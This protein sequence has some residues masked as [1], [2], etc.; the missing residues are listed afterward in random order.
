[1]KILVAPQFGIGDALMTTPALEI[2]KRYRPSWKIDVFTMKKPINDV[3]KNNPNID[4]LIHYPLLEK[5]K[6]SSILFIL[7]NLTLRY[8]V[9]IN[10]FPSN[11][12]DYNIF[13]FLTLSKNRIGFR[14]KNSSFL[15]FD[16]LLNKKCEE[17]Y[18]LHCVEENL[19][20]LKLL[21]IEYK[22]DIPKLSIYLTQEEID[23]GKEFLKNFGNA[24]KIG[25][26]TGSSSFKSH[27]NKRW[28][29]ENFLEVVNYYKDYMFFLFG[30]EEERQENEFILKNSIHQNCFIVNNKT[31]R[32][33][34]SIMK[35]LDLFISND[36][37]LMHLAA[38]VN[39]PVIA[40]FGPTNPTWVGPWGVKHKIVR[41]DLEC[42]PCFVYSPKP[43]ECKIEE[44]FKC[45]N[46][47]TPNIVIKAIEEMLL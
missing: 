35:N 25:I 37:G 46:Q 14:Y 7:R 18:N 23:K 40:I 15:Q 34:A 28:K 38:A 43:L 1:M 9:T 4:N 29:K 33:T 3:F 13:S 20:L 8:D 21:G 36:S 12:R 45:L 22:G 42:S 2:L 5:N 24:V 10:F 32:E 19:K 6:L 26:H 16:F 39:L 17:D 27:K 47:I 44:K 11:R 30:T 41:L 31:I